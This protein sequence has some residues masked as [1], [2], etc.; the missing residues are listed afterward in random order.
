[1]GW[2]GASRPAENDEYS[3]S[4][5]TN[6]SGN[7]RS[8]GRAVGRFTSPLENV[9]KRAFVYAMF[10]SFGAAFKAAS[11]SISLFA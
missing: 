5:I 11:S 6:G 2:A 3:A 4:L 7:G 8:L 9:A 1:M 10:L